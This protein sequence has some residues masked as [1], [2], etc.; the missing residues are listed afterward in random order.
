M[1]CVTIM[2]V[3]HKGEVMS[4]IGTE[5]LDKK[6]CRVGIIE[7]DHTQIELL[8]QYLLRSELARSWNV[9]HHDNALIGLSD[10][11]KQ[12][13]DFLIVDINLPGMDGFSLGSIIQDLYEYQTPIIFIS[14]DEK[15]EQIYNELKPV[16]SSFLLKPIK[17][18]ELIE[19]IKSM[20]I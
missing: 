1:L 15:N 12:K 11:V 18:K 17:Q 9:N 7:D 3:R 10:F 19:T 2:F 8:H 13:Y 4:S 5:F 20:K 6:L 16:N 14:A